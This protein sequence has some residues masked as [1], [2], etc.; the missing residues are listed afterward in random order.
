VTIDLDPAA[1]PVQVARAEVGIKIFSEKD[2]VSAP[3]DFR[4]AADGVAG[5]NY[6]FVVTGTLTRRIASTSS[7]AALGPRLFQ[8]HKARRTPISIRARLPS[9]WQYGV[10]TAALP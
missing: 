7:I 4:T 8:G 1:N 2:Q 3:L 9:R 10:L 5:G 6:V